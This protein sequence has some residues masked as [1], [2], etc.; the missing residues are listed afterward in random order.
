M[1]K[2]LSK[3]D[4]LFIKNYG[5]NS[6]KEYFLEVDVQYQKKKLFSLHSDFTFLLERKKIGKCNKLICNMQDKKKICCSQKGFKTSIKSWIDT[7]KG[8]HT[9]PI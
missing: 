7:K 1:D 6:I 9:N 3:F 5:Q 8:A 4:E 2:S